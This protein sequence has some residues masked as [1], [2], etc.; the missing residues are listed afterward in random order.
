MI[1]D[2]VLLT[3]ENEFEFWAGSERSAERAARSH[4]A[5]IAQ[6]RMW[7][8]SEVFAVAKFAAALWG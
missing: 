1:A 6:V 2:V 7:H 8:D 5:A 3:Q 4:F